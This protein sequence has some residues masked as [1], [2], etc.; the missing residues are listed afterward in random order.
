MLATWQKMGTGVTLNAASYEVFLD[1]PW[2][3]AVFIQAQD[4]IHR[5]GSKKPV[6]IYNLVCKNTIDERVLE[7]VQSKGAIS[8]YVVDDII[9]PNAVE[10]LKKYI[11]D[12]A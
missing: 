10:S 11:E 8:D 4:R 5:I 7:L 12:L 1:T 3:E 9:S 2:T 6:F